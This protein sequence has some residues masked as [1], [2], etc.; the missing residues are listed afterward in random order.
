VRSG[1]LFF[2][3]GADRKPEKQAFHAKFTPKAFAF[4]RAFYRD[5]TARVIKIVT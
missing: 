1:T 3:N 2:P 5:N 4:L